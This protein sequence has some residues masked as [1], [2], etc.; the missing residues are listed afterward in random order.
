M[1]KQIYMK[2]V[3]S[4]HLMITE[5]HENCRH[6]PFSIRLERKKREKKRREKLGPFCNISILNVGKQS[7]INLCHNVDLNVDIVMVRNKTKGD[8][9][10]LMALEPRALIPATQSNN[11][12]TVYQLTWQS[13][14]HIRNL[15]A[16]L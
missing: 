2:T 13:D 10:T 9:S 3:K 1:P 16:A 14:M 11:E 4:K 5:P 8:V 12:L 6:L 7:R 15:K